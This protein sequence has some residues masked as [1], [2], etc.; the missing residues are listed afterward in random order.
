MSDIDL[1]DWIEQNNP[2][3]GWQPIGVSSSAFKG[4]FDGNNHTI[5]GLTI[6]RPSTEN[7]G[8]FGYIDAATIKNLTVKGNVEGG[9]HV[10]GICGAAGSVTFSNCNFTQGGSFGI[11]SHGNNS[12]GIAGYVTGQLIVSQCSCNAT[13]LGNGDNTGG[14]IG[15]A[16]DAVTMSNNQVRGNIKGT[17]LYTGGIIGYILIYEQISLQKCIAT[18]TV[19]GNDNVGGVV[20][21]YQRSGYKKT[22]DEINKCSF[23]GKLKGANNVGGILGYSFFMNTWH[24]HY[25]EPSCSFTNS[26]AIVDIDATGDHI[27]GLIGKDEGY[28]D[29][30]SVSNRYGD[31]TY[32]S[33]CHYEISNSYSSG[34]ISGKNYVG[35]LV[36]Y[37]NRGSITKCFSNTS[38]YGTSHVGGIVGYGEGASDNSLTLKSNLSICNVVNASE[39]NAGR[40]YGSVGSNVTIGANGSADENGALT[41][42][43]VSIAGVVQDISDNEQSGASQG[44]STLKYRANYVAKGWDFNN[45]WDIQETETYP[46]K[47][48]Q[49]A[50]PKIESDLVS[51]ETTISGKSINGGKVYLQIGDNY[52]DSVECS[53]NHFSFD[54][55]ALQSGDLVRLYAVVDTMG[56]SLY[57]DAYVS[58]PGSGTETDP[59]RV[60]T[61]A[62][63]QGVYKKGYYKLMND[64]DL[65]EWINENSPKNGWPAIGKNGL[66]AV[67]F[68]GGGHTVSGLWCNTAADYNGLFSNF[69]DGYIKNLNVKVAEGKEVK[70]GDCTGIVIG[71][72][73]NGIIDNVTASGTVNGSKRCGGIVG[74]AD[75]LKISSSK[76]DGILTSDSTNAILGGIVGEIQGGEITKSQA[77]STITAK[78]ESTIAGALVGKNNASVSS[79]FTSGAVTLTGKNSYGGGLIGQ[80][81]DSASVE[82]CYSTADA[83]STL[84]AAG[85]VAYNYGKVSNS[86]SKGNVNSEFYGAGAV[87]YNDGAKAT[88]NNLVAGNPQVNVT[89]KSGWSIRV[90]GGFKNG[91]SQPGENNYA[92]STMILSVNGVPKKVTDNILDGYAKTEDELKSKA[93]YEKLSW[94]FSRV[95][96]IEEGKAWPTLDMTVY[97][98]VT[99]VTLDQK[100]LTLKKGQTA[101]LKATV[102]P[103]DATNKTVAWSSSDTSIATVKDG[104]VRGVGNGKATIIATSTD[105]TNLSDSAIVTV[106]APVNDTIVLK[107]T[108]T[109]K[110]KTIM[111]PVYL[112]N[113]DPICSFQ[114]DVYLPDGMDIATNSKGKYDIQFAGRQ[115]DTHSITSNKIST[116]AVRVIAFS[117][118]NDNFSGKSGALINIPI[119]I[120]DVT[121][122]DYNISIR[123]IVL[124][125]ASEKEYYCQ[126]ANG[127]IH[128]NDVIMGDA[129]SDGKVSLADV[130]S[131]VNY[132]AEK[133]SGSFCFAAADMNNN[134]IINVSDV[135]A[136]V[137][138]LAE[139]KTPASAKKNFLA[140]ANEVTTND[141]M[142][143]SNITVAPGE[144]ATLPVNLE[145]S[146]KYCSFQFDILLPKGIT[147]DSTVN[148]SGKVRYSASLVT[149]RCVDHSLTSNLIR[150]NRYRVI[151]FSLSNTDVEGANGPVVNIKLKA[152]KDAAEGDYTLK[153]ER[154]VLATADEKEYYPADSESTVTVSANT[155]VNSISID[156]SS[157]K[158]YDLQGR[159]VNKPTQGVY[160]ING[161]KVV[162]K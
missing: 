157:V 20:G 141:K 17:G 15:Y 62:D 123:N 114:F 46:Y 135:N 81:I 32:V 24:P 1:T 63:L 144:T 23:V 75:N 124:A 118:A 115:E 108:T 98:L 43:K 76:F 12:G 61:A 33:I 27:G 93:T 70:G 3:N 94:S 64:V 116:G 16:N 52:R 26:Y 60:Y 97:G 137:N 38:I 96:K 87:G 29:R 95:W 78:G 68:D 22:S 122:G 6:N 125:D 34:S 132:I 133:P 69:P 142:Y 111:Y 156:P 88:V 59:Y 100:T 85:L 120:G 138:V 57:T 84:Y 11:K 21:G 45:D 113:E 119:T 9:T 147:V 102:K 143:C 7:V 14:L 36:G 160:I 101:T 37:K 8:F 67:Y 99:S 65:T 54:V 128:V 80:N 2:S 155:G 112:N 140:T 150:G 56:Q 13:I 109:L 161:K 153:M 71:H 49:A 127:V 25:D 19:Q 159:K 139:V 136:I 130:N 41:T 48:W 51:Q 28:Y 39:S 83:T 89:D 50:P 58:Y 44:A 110:N 121:K 82:N 149:S 162:I 152:E 79:S 103:D 86:Y 104:V 106:Y 134:G 40:V 31:F 129:N 55:P 5:S 74:V 117:I 77:S 4:I 73:A 154:V 66:T 35:G 72:F 47:P 18:G 30:W 107:D 53:G 158:V 10:G 92:L 146:G 148:Q 91:A 90:L 145:N 131:T 126:D 42:C 151:V 105:G